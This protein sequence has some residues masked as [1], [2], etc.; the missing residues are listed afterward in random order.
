MPP[1]L[2]TLFNNLATRLEQLS[3]GQRVLLG[4][5][6]VAMVL[7]GVYVASRGQEDY[8]VLYANLSIPDA[9]A[10]VNRLKEMNR[11]YRLVDGGTTVMV[12]RALKNDL[13]LETADELTSEEPISL[14]KIPPILQ[15]DVQKEWLR[16]FNTDSLGATLSTIAGIRH[17]KVMI[18][19]PEAS[20]FAEGEDPIQASVMLMVEPGFRLKEKQITT[21]KNLVAHAV[22]GL[23]VENVVLSDNYGNMLDDS[24]NATGGH[25][26]DGQDDNPRET[27][28]ARM[29]KDVQKKVIALLEPVV[30]RDNAVVSVSAEMNFDQSR[31]KVHTVTPTLEDPNKQLAT[32]LVVSQQTQSEEYGGAAAKAGEG[33]RVGTESNVAPSYQLKSSQSGGANGDPNKQYKSLKQTT[34]Y[35]HSE[36]DKEIIYATGTLK[37]LTVAVVLNKVLTLQEVDELKSTIANAAGLNAQRGDSVDV[38]GFQFSEAPS[39]K[40]ADMLAAMQ[41]S[42]QQE[43][44]MQGGYLLTLLILGLGALMVVKQALGKTFSVATAELQARHG[45]PVAALPTVMYSEEGEVITPDML[46]TDERGMVIA[47]ATKV[48]DQKG[49]LIELGGVRREDLNLPD[50]VPTQGPEVEYMRQAI[51]GFIQK[52]EET[53]AKMIMAYIHE[54]ENV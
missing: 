5:V 53:S 24:P 29:E 35:A 46:E 43:M 36:E 40:N 38:K 31:A 44:L 33:G 34:N 27:Q 28:Q 6:L 37:R 54:G 26:R 19:Q 21:I 14:A 45:T 48:Y 30:G 20:V 50:V 2:S 49:R 1:F 52:D 13:V 10:T 11:P 47:P 4:T 17:A 22:P 42:K 7:A 9:A 16:K 23:T 41:A 25:G 3:L 12:P 8:D 18:A 15:G 51:Y 32:G 39:K